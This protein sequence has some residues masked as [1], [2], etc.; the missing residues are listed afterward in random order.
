MAAMA[1][2]I[3][4]RRATSCVKRIPDYAASAAG[5]AWQPSATTTACRGLMRVRTA[6]FPSASVSTAP[7]AR[8]QLCDE[9]ATRSQ[10]SRAAPPL[11]GRVAQRRRRLVC[12]SVGEAADADRGVYR[13]EELGWLEFERLANG[14]LAAHP[15]LNEARWSGR[16][17]EGRLAVICGD[18]ELPGVGPITGPVLV[19]IAWSPAVPREPLRERARDLA[20]EAGVVPRC[21]LVITNARDDDRD[22]SA[23]PDGL[24]FI[25]K[26][27]RLRLGP[28]ALSA[29]LDSDAALR[30]R[31]PAVLGLR[32][33]AGLAGAAVLDRST[34]DLDAAR[35]LG[36]VFVATR[37]YARAL[38][39]LERHRFAVVTGPPE[40]GKTAIARMLALAKLTEGWEA[41]ECRQPDQLWRHFSRDRSQL[42]IADDAFGSTE[43]RPDAAERW[44]L[45][46][47]R[48]LRA[49]DDRHWLIWTSRPGPLKA[50]LGR[51]H[52]EHGVER[53]PRPAEVRV[54]AAELGL[55]EKASILFRHGR[56]RPLTG[57]GVDLLRTHGWAIVDHPH[58]TPERIRRFVA[59]R[60]PALEG[61]D[62]PVARADIGEAVSAEIRE[63]T[64][65]M[66]T[67]LAA[68]PPEYRG[69]LVT[70]LDTPP[71]PVP[72]RDLAAAARRH[73]DAGLQHRPADLVERLTTTSCGSFGRKA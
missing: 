16:A 67:S 22:A 28:R 69:L 1:E 14:L 24:E 39:V 15:G 43:Y 45:E 40:M 44:A 70:L 34:A 47:D 63:P 62:A 57:R 64:D 30:R 7:R 49:M 65:A 13:F 61:V 33:A 37:A 11:L 66:A 48:V 35:R 31:V 4:V 29:V 10:A 68:L 72:E 53:F 27:R 46:L 2:S 59:H 5:R 6:S 3:R 19:L 58:F 41:H 38:A 12:A 52:R 9:T 21:A 56:S 73:L 51:I 8:R 54:D 60:L 36:R 71:G 32:D 50:G 17:D 20:R 26:A 23:W 55:E 18:A 42:F 25:P